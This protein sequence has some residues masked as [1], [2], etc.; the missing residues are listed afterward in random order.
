M[1]KM[2]D[3]R[4]FDHRNIPEQHNELFTDIGEMK[5]YFILPETIWLTYNIHEEPL[6]SHIPDHLKILGNDLRIILLD[7]IIYISRLNKSVDFNIH[8]NIA[9]NLYQLNKRRKS[10]H[11]SSS[12]VGG[13]ET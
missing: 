7:L 10:R 9:G 5:S 8:Q 3:R 12:S 2:V 1:W 6:S 13:N 11:M 4:S